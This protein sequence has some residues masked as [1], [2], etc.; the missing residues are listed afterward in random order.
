MF[1]INIDATRASG[2]SLI[3]ALTRSYKRKVL[4][5]W[6]DN[7]ECSSTFA[8]KMPAIHK[9]LVVHH[10]YKGKIMQVKSDY[11]LSVEA[12]L[13]ITSYP[14]RVCSIF[15]FVKKIIYCYSC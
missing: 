4:G 3:D 1:K 14:W 11:K 5:L 12:L 9:S 13:G 15:K 7:F 2:L 8:I 6:Y 10:N